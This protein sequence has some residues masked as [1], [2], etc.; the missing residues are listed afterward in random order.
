MPHRLPPTPTE[1]V[2]LLRRPGPYDGLRRKDDLLDE[3]VAAVFGLRGG[4]A[5]LLAVLF[6]AGRFTPA[7][8]RHWLRERR[9]EC[10]ALREAAGVPQGQPA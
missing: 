9:L 1:H 10:L 2:A 3:G 7:Q 6:R 5:E 8:A 4:E